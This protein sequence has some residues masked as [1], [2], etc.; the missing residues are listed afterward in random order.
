MLNI[1]DF[2]VHIHDLVLVAYM[3]PFFSIHDPSFVAYMTLYK[4]LQYSIVNIRLKP[5]FNAND[6]L[7]I[8]DILG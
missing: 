7:L 5:F 3:T 1:H 2:E 8:Y 4:C 6:P